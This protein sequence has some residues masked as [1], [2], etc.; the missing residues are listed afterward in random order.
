[1]NLEGQ[2]PPTGT[3]EVIGFKRIACL[4]CSAV[5]GVELAAVPQFASGAATALAVT[6]KHR[7][8]NA[9]DV[10]A[11]EH[12]SDLRAGRSVCLA[13]LQIAAF[14]A[15]RGCRHLIAS[16][17]A[18][19]RP[20]CND[21]TAR[22]SSKPEDQSA[23]VWTFRPPPRDSFGSQ[24]LGLVPTSSARISALL[25]TRRRVRNRRTGES[26][27]GRLHG[28]TQRP[29]NPISA[30]VGAIRVPSRKIVKG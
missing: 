11:P 28:I 6:R 18:R 30:A 9:L 12:W 29:D 4:L 13:E 17:L 19:C 23:L 10:T 14:G 21:P 20:R 5:K 7:R 24:A 3:L 8:G 22:T 27:D 2:S 26:D 1:M 16:P 25:L 15:H